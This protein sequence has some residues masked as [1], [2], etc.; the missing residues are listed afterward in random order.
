MFS[1]SLSF[2]KHNERE[3]ENVFLLIKTEVCLHTSIPA[4][5]IYEQIQGKPCIQHLTLTT[6]HTFTHIALNAVVVSITVK[7]INNLLSFHKLE[8]ISQRGTWYIIAL[9]SY[10]LCTLYPDIRHT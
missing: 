10:L 6:N 3:I 8:G 7:Q 9:S 5:S 4:H 1:F 2:L